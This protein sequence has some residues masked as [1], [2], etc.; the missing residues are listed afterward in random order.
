MN[1]KGPF[2]GWFKTVS[3]IAVSKDG[4]V[5]VTDFYNHRVQ[6][7]RKDGT[8]LFSIGELGTGPGQFTYPLGVDVAANG[9]VFVVDFG[10]NRIQKWVRK[11]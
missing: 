2:N 3:S 6:V 7:F 5:F 11:Q 9:T 1:I 8:F 4:K 10:N